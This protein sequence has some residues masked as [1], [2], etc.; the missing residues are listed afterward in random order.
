MY[1][2]ILVPID[3]SPTSQRALAEAIGL[4]RLTGG[5]LRLM[6]VLDQLNSARALSAYDGYA[7]NWLGELR[8]QAA[9]LLE[10]AALQAAGER[11]EAD[12]SLHDELSP[13][14]ADSVVEEADRWHADVIVLGTHGR[15]GIGRFLM[16]SGAESILRM[17]KVPVL[18]VRAA[19]PASPAADETSPG[20]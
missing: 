15:R 4:A 18:L 11:V 5:Q 12:T 20:S 6:H 17:A 1:K 8:Q 2:R 3:G 13:H 10:Q 19:E 7:S 9:K 14:L 16:G